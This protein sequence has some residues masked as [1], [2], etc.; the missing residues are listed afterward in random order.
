M[1]RKTVRIGSCTECGSDV[2]SRQVFLDDP[3]TIRGIQLVWCRSETG[4]WAA[5]SNSECFFHY[6]EGTLP[7]RPRDLFPVE[8]DTTDN[9]TARKEDLR[10]RLEKAQ[11]GEWPEPPRF[12]PDSPYRD[13]GGDL[14]GG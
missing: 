13:Y 11:K 14:P 8:S 7:S 2:I 3:N 1:I 10:E 4:Y 6:G 12:D 9:L 5:C